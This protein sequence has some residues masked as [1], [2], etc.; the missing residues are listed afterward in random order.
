MNTQNVDRN[1]SGKPRL[2]LEQKVRLLARGF[3]AAERRRRKREQKPA[4]RSSFGCLP[5]AVLSVAM[6][7]ALTLPFN[8]R[9]ADAVSAFEQANAAFVAGNYRAAIAQY[10][11]ILARHGASAPVLFNL[12][13]AYYRAGQFGAAIL[14]YERAQVLAPRDHSIEVNL[15]LA[16]E[17]AG[18]PAPT[19]N[20]V[21]QLA[22]V[23]SPNTLAWAGSFALIALCLTVGIRRFFPHFDQAKVLGGVA[24]VTLL[25]V[26][27]TFAIRWPEFDRAIVVTANTPAR[28]APAGTAAELFALKAGETVSIG[29]NYGQFIL[30]RTADGRSG[31][32]SDQNVGRVFTPRFITRKQG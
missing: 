24:V 30:V 25:A 15:G 12:G 23:V 6:V 20:A 4:C 14:D 9:A 8:A 2:S 10:D 22:Q 26:A 11:E 31:W 32:V 7:A 5:R 29:K 17:K 1:V 27:A 18:V 16:R 13:N 3:R 21:Q 19:L 28:I